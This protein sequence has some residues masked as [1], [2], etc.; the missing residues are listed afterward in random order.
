MQR[1]A[2][3]ALC[4]LA[5]ARGRLLKNI[6]MNFAAYIIQMEDM[7]CAN[8]CNQLDLRM[9]VVYRPLCEV[10]GCIELARYGVATDQ[11]RFCALHS[12]LRM[13]NFAS[14]CE[15]P[16]CK[17]LATFSFP[18]EPARFCSEHCVSGMY[19]NVQFCEYDGCYRRADFGSMHQA[20]FCAIHRAKY[21]HIIGK[22][23]C[24]MPFCLEG[25]ASPG[26][27]DLSGHFCEAHFT[28]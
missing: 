17:R 15:R 9:N 2:R 27:K 19:E 1:F 7:N 20:R 11:R 3:S 10:H 13:I 16:R 28:Y 26:N 18:K 21:A 25:V 8:S 5:N 4:F 24:E 14:F 12:T 6:K 22:K 23:Y